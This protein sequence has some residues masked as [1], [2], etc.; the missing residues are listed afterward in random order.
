MFEENGEEEE[1]RILERSLFNLT[2]GQQLKILNFMKIE[3]EEMNV[4]KNAT[5]TTTTTT[6]TAA[7]APAALKDHRDEYLNLVAL[8][9]I[10]VEIPKI[11]DEKGLDFQGDEVI[12]EEEDEIENKEETPFRFGKCPTCQ[13]PLEKDGSCSDPGGNCDLPTLA[14]IP[15]TTERQK[16]NLKRKRM[17][18]EGIPVP[19]WKIHF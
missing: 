11:P 18:V 8:T 7:T 10:C 3:L 15:I 6:N 4:G 9:T 12:G 17:E 16:A 1:P 14:D 5:T 2:F 13:A 19:K